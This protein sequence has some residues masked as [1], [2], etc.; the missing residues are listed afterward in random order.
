MPLRAQG[1]IA[2][3]LLANEHRD[4]VIEGCLRRRYYSREGEPSW[5]QMEIWVDH[6]T[7]VQAT[8]IEE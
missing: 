6:C 7:A 1:K 2:E 5:G 8:K 4:V 3:T